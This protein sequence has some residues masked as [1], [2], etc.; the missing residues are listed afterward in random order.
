MKKL[1][2]ANE[3]GGVGKTTAAYNFAAAMAKTGKR[4]LCVALDPQGNLSTYMNCEPNEGE[5]TIM[6]LIHEAIHR[7]GGCREEDL[8]AAIRKNEEGV[9][10][11][12]ADISL[13]QADMALAVAFSREK[14]LKRI[15]DHPFFD[16]SFD[17][18]LIDCPPNLGIVVINALM[19]AD[20]VMIP[21]QTKNFALKG[22]VMLEGAIEQVQQ[23][24]P[25][26][27]IQAVFINMTRQNRNSNCIEKLLK[28]RYGDLV[29]KTTIPDL[30]EADTS[31]IQ[32]R[33]LVNVD[34][35][36][37]GQLYKDAASE[38]MSRSVIGY[39]CSK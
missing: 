7:K 22:L 30:V 20:G 12:P 3:K 37:L 5:I 1:V 2:F 34:R 25:K 33:S 36:R 38:L 19:A 18:C 24:K 16:G 29:L 23:D 35:S 21:V 17:T 31:T 14:I 28:E 39:R 11:I 26:L 6:E 15:L 4:V 9:F 10:C 8:R 32:K 27:K 13:S